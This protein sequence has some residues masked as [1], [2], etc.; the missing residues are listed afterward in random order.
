VAVV[1]LAALMGS[2]AR[3]VVEGFQGVPSME[4]YLAAAG[5]GDPYS[6]YVA[7]VWFG[8]AQ[9]LIAGYAIVQVSGWA[10]EDT[11]GVLEAVL[12]QPVPRWWVVLERGLTLAAGI[13]ILSG[14]GGVASGL[15]ANGVGIHLDA[16][17]VWRASWL[18]LP[19]GLSFA[20][21][22]AVGV[23]RWPRATVGVLAFLAMVSY[24]IYQLAAF[25][26]W[27]AW[28]PD[29]SVFKLYGDPLTTGI[30]WRGLDIMLAIVAAG[31][32]AG[33]LFMQRREIGR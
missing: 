11:E 17:S 2:L 23:G 14:A 29:L 25:M 13:A 4:L 32:A 28:V 18:L 27:P 31:F 26:S 12:S 21:A 7:L 19:F 6:A 20:A 33:V 15:A 3:T 22:G 16:A 24:L 8:I 30:Y 9:L 10:A 5:G 1:L